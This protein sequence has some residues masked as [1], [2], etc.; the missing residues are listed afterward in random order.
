MDRGKN[1]VIKNFNL[2]NSFMEQTLIF[3]FRFQIHI[4]IKNIVM[5]IFNEKLKEISKI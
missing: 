1:T 5:L 4:R 2:I 3:T